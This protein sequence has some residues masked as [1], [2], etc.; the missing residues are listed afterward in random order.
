MQPS[1]V[2]T[3]VFA[4]RFLFTVTLRRPDLG[5]PAYGVRQPRLLPAERSVEK[6]SLLLQA[7]P[8]PKYKA[9]FT[10]AYGAGLRASPRWLR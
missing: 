8:G 5:Y 7:P 2:N 3:A 4:L 9:A 1:S 6:V 10:T